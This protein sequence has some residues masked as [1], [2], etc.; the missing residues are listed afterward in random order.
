MQAKSVQPPVNQPVNQPAAQ[1]PPILNATA[2]STTIFRVEQ[3]PPRET[4][5]QHQEEEQKKDVE[6]KDVEMADAE[7]KAAQLKVYQDDLTENILKYAST[8]PPEE[9]EYHLAI[10]RKMFSSIADRL[11]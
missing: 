4:R 11:Y 9:R 2:G 10:S 6:V 1:R 7:I 8:L 3:E 5:F